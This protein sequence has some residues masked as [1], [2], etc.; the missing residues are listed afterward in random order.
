MSSV[1]VP[2]KV[3]HDAEGHVITLE[4]IN[5]EVFRGK[6]IEAEDNMNVHMQEIIM[7]ARDGKTS[8]LQH[9][10]IRGSK[11]RYVEELA[12]VKETSRRSWFGCAICTIWVIL[13][14]VGKSRILPQLIIAF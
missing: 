7:T 13:A 9:V 1:G 2:I 14:D 6:L 4:T 3:L 11:I 10:Y 5:G 12:D 8:S